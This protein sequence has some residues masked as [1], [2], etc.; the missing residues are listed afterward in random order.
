MILT[1]KKVILWDFDGVILDSD[2]IRVEGFKQSL[3][4][5]PSNQ[6]QAL[7]DYHHRNG[8]LSRYNKFKFFFN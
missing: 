1:S 8:G 7:L 4:D 5:Y 2:K 6:V 3:K